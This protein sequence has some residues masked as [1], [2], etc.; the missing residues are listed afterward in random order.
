MIEV[1]RNT[2]YTQAFGCRFCLHIG[3]LA[4]FF[5]R[6]KDGRGP[7]LELFTPWH[8]FRWSQGYRNPRKVA[9]G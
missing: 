8:W 9:A 5:G 2:A 4:I 3:S 1:R 7:R 6:M